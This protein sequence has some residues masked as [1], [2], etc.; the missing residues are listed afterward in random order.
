[1]MA[2]SA[3]NRESDVTYAMLLLGS[4]IYLHW[5]LR[6]Y[7]IPLSYLQETQV[8]EMRSAIQKKYSQSLPSGSIGIGYVLVGLHILGYLLHT[9]SNSPSFLHIAL[10]LIG[11][12]VIA[13]ARAA[14]QAFCE[15]KQTH[16]I[17][18]VPPGGRAKTRAP[19]SCRSIFEELDHPAK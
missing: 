15:V 13:Q 3:T 12:G 2:E 7:L 16:D 4:V 8:D 11:L 9:D 17:E 6:T 10:F 1:M 18:Y 19:E 14:V 5:A